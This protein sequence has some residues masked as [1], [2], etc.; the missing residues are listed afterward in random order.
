MSP[1]R[2]EP[3]VLGPFNLLPI[4]LDS[5]LRTL[6]R[7]LLFSYT[8]YKWFILPA[9]NG[10]KRL[11]GSSRESSIQGVLKKKPRHILINADFL[12][13]KN[14]ARSI[15][16]IITVSHE[17]GIEY[18]SLIDE[19]GIL[20]S[21]LESTPNLTLYRNQYPWKQGKECNLSI[22]IVTSFPKQHFIDR[23]K[24]LAATDSN[25]R[26]TPYDLYTTISSIP[27]VD[28]IIITKPSLTL[29]GCP[30]TQIGFA[31]IWYQMPSCINASND[32]S[33]Q[34]NAPIGN[35]VMRQALQGYSS[36]RQ[37]FGK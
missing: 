27:Q 8:I 11:S 9:I 13:G 21:P 23:I 28:L 24:E 2:A 19:E 36:C 1:T 35:T 34:P 18:I 37:N 29:E 7:F 4:M 30:P 14:L 20:R 12:H 6:H 3:P 32:F 17:Y 10:I 26:F 16:E 5:L 33:H 25:F 22:N 15:N 31:E